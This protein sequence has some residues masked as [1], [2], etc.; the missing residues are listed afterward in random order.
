VYSLLALVVALSLQ[1]GVNYANDYSDGIR[2]T[3]SPAAGRVGPVRLVGQDLANPTDV[4]LA[5][6]VAF[7]LAG[8]WGF[9]LVA[10][11]EAWVML[12]IGA[13]SVVAAWYY[14]GG[15][16]PYGYSGFGEVFVFV[17][18]GLVATLGTLYT[19]AGVLT[20]VG[21]LGSVGVGALASAVLVANNLRDIPSDAAA[22]KR[23]LAVRL[24]D[25]GTRGLYAGLVA[26]SVVVVVACALLGSWFA[27]LALPAYA[28]LWPALTALRSGAVGRDLIPVLARTGQ[29]QLLWSVL[30]AV[31]LALHHHL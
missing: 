29:F 2:G 21:V 7:F 14:T 23:T 20:L 27:L 6:I 16:R 30:L 24:G 13:L 12:P 25:G 28:F 9:A 1:V 4:R 19:Q 18:F 8:L 5:A 22:G 31:G 11:S 15:R 17:F 26:V 3:D 10:L